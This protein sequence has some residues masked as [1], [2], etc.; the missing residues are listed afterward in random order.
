MRVSILPNINIVNNKCLLY[1]IKEYTNALT[2]TYMTDEPS[3]SALVNAQQ[4][5]FS[6]S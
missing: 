3:Y 2:D 4:H 1:Y 6:I 5:I